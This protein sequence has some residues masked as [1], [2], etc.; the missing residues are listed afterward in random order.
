MII[1]KY[2]LSYDVASESV[3]I[4]DYYMGPQFQHETPLSSP[5]VETKGDDLNTI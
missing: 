1:D 5:T 2:I 3:T 4:R